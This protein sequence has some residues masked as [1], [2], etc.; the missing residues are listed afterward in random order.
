M[1]KHPDCSHLRIDKKREQRAEY[2]E[3]GQ[4]GS[5]LGIYPRGTETKLLGPRP[6]SVHSAALRSEGT[7]GDALGGP[8]R[9]LRLP[10]PVSM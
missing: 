1:S 9:G 10:G 4:R 6:L 2:A 3:M 5:G 8:G 7:P